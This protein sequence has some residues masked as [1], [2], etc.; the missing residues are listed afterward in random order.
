PD[1]VA[2]VALRG[3]AVGADDGEIDQAVL[4]QVAAGVVGD[5]G[6][7]DAV[8]AELPGRPRRPLVA[9]TRLVDPDVDF[10][11]LVVRQVDRRRRRAPIDR[12]QPAGVAMCQHVDRLAGLFLRHNRLDQRQPVAADRL[13]DGDVLVVDRGGALIGYGDAALARLI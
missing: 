11:A 13:V 8:V 2:D 7:R 3:D 10:D 4:H 1:L 9:W 6:V 5:H 12:R